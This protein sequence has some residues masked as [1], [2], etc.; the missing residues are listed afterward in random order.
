VRRDRL[1]EAVGLAI[2]AL[3][4]VS[5]VPLAPTPWL[6]DL[7]YG[8]LIAVVGLGGA[9]LTIAASGAAGVTRASL[10][11][12]FR[13]IALWA[14][15]AAAIVCALAAV[16]LTAQTMSL[17]NIVNA[18]VNTLPY[19]L[20]QP[21]AAL[22]YLAGAALAGDER[23]LIAVLGWP[24]RLRSAAEVVTAVFLAAFGATLFLAGYAGPTLPGPVWVLLKTAL[25]AATLLA[26][27]ARFGHVAAEQRLRA[28][29]VVLLPVALVN[30]AVTVVV[31]AR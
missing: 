5:L 10:A 19:L 18:Q 20:L 1:A 9:A 15:C 6:P 3:V 7:E 29:W 17:R 8:L 16:A 14:G 23:G 26:L 21:G 22:V 25:I 27:R 24:A 30:L 31:L 2:A 11:E 28:A 4:L 12:R 13:A